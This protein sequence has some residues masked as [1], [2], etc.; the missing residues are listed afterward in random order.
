MDD[1]RGLAGRPRTT[2]GKPSLEVVCSQ[3]DGLTATLSAALGEVSRDDDLTH[4][5]HTYPAGLHPRAARR[6]IE[7]FPGAVVVD[8]F[9]GGGTVLIEAMRAGRAAYGADL[10]PVAC[11]VS[12]TRTA[13]MSPDDLTA[14]RSAA[15]RITE[16]AR[17]PDAL[18]P[19][20]I[21]RVVAPWYEEHVAAELESL[22]RGVNAAPDA[23][24]GLLRGVLSS[25]LVKVS[26]R[27][28]DTSWERVDT[29]R[30][31]GTTAILFHKKARE[32]GRRLEA[33]AAACGDAPAAVVG[34]R[35]ARA[36]WATPAA[37]L[38]LTSPPYPGV[39][40]YLP[41]QDLRA[42]WLGLELPEARE[43]TSRRAWLAD[44]DAASRAWRAD[45]EAWMTRAAAGL[46]P[47]GSLVV[48][49]GDGRVGRRDLDARA[50]TL[51]AADA[52][53][54]RAVAWASHARPD[55][56][57][58]GVRWEHILVLCGRGSGR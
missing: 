41:I 47:G 33:L 10:S 51:D 20:A 1:A 17:H 29:R 27:R 11:L 6:L 5:F 2:E 35:D 9:C 28:S 34:Q 58:H 25:L 40:D 36:P 32:L 42:A 3:D 54:L 16:V 7:A 46:A 48:V 52:V 23:V 22:R 15:R 37:D 56:A 45:T 12:A 57:I 24:R 55:H 8:P 26:L 13:R 43:L 50:A 39:Y 30:P 21:E 18:P 49:I 31:P 14:F 44:P 19:V 38:I 4:G 53:G